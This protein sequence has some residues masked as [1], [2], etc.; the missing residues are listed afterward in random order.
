MPKVFLDTNIFVYAND[1]R[2]QAKQDRAIEIVVEQLRGGAGVVS[3]QI[4]MEYAA[5]AISK[6]SQPLEAVLRQLQIM[7]RFQVVPVHGELIRNAMVLRLGHALSFWDAVVCQAAVSAGC[8]VLLS[9]DMQPGASIA[10]VR[11]ENPF[12]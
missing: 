6:L 1:S 5:V 7:E 4:L 3:T 11:I 9:E 2:D 12:G 10:S 8:T